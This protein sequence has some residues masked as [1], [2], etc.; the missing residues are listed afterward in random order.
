MHH[1]KLIWR[2]KFNSI[3]AHS[4]FLMAFISGHGLLRARSFTCF[5]GHSASSGPAQCC[6]FR[7]TIDY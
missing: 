3:T 1:K 4:K 2:E 6:D 5:P 7:K